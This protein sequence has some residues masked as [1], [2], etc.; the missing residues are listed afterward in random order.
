VKSN[1]KEGTGL[2]GR[3]GELNLRH[4]DLVGKEE[5]ERRLKANC[6]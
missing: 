3:N 1:S 5:K 6:C 4:D 2:L